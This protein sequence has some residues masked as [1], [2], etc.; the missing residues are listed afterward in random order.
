MEEHLNEFAIPAWKLEIPCTEPLREYWRVYTDMD[1]SCWY[2]SIALALDTSFC[3]ALHYSDH[4]RVQRGLDLRK[5]ICEDTK[6]YNC[7]KNRVEKE[8]RSFVPK[9]I[10]I[11][12]SAFFIGQ[13]GWSMTAEALQMGIIIILTEREHGGLTSLPFK[14]KDHVEEL[15]K[16]HK[17]SLGAGEL[18]QEA[19]KRDILPERWLLVAC[20][21]DSH[22]QSILCVDKAKSEVYGVF[23]YNS[24]IEFFLNL[25]T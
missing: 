2:H 18:I 10:D 20:I 16:E 7:A 11:K 14:H 5:L 4:D 15:K 8:L 22:F 21:N 23:P 9:Q 25:S 17:Y 12:Q 19:R 6:L 1:G 24:V 3:T 13:F